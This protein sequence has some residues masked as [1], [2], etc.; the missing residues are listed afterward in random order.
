MFGLTQLIKRDVIHIQA[1]TTFS[2]YYFLHLKNGSKVSNAKQRTIIV[3][4]RE[5]IAKF[6]GFH[7]VLY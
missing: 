7:G 3:N 4:R 5:K 6:I 1:E 2:S